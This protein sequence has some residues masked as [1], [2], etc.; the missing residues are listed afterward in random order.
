MSVSSNDVLLA[1]EAVDA[2]LDQAVTALG[3]S[4]LKPV[5]DAIASLAA[6]AVAA[7]QSASP[8]AAVEIVAAD[9]AAE[10]TEDKKF[11]GPGGVL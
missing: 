8:I 11:G 2:L 4:E 10:A 5:F 6:K 9:A 1:I 7:S 3:A